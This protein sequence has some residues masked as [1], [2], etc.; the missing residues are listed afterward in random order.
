MNEETDAPNPR[1][2]CTNSPQVL[3]VEQLLAAKLTGHAIKADTARSVADRDSRLADKLARVGFT[4][5]RI[6][7]SVDARPDSQGIHCR[8]C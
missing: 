6:E 3:R 5:T 1:H 4:Q 7:G 8:P 2:K